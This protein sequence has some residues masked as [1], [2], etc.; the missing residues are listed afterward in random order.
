MKVIASAVIA[1]GIVFGLGELYVARAD[2]GRVWV[3]MPVCQF[4]DGNPDGR[5]CLWIDP[6][7]GQGFVSLSE[8]YR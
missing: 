1:F 4:E 2:D 5:T 8:N 6:G 3:D 7:T